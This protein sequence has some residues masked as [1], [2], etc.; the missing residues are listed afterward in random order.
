MIEEK[1][2]VSFIIPVYNS[3]KTIEEIILS[4]IS[5]YCEK[6]RVEIILVNDNSKDASEEICRKVAEK[7][8]RVILIN[9]SKNFGQHN[10]LLTGMRY[11]SGDIVICL[12]DDM[13]NP[14]ED[15]EFLINKLKTGY[16][17]IYG[18]YIEHRESLARRVGSAVNS[19]MATALI[20]KPRNIEITSFFAMKKFIIKEVIKYKGP[21][22]YLPGLIFRATSKIG[23]VTVTHRVR[24]SGKTNYNMEKLISLWMNGF[25][26]YSVKPLRFASLT[27]V[28]TSLCGFIYFTVIIIKK[29]L[30]PMVPLGWTSVMAVILF[31]GG[32]QLLTIGLIGEYIGRMFLSVNEK[33]Q[34]VIKEIIRKKVK[35]QK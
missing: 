33:P 21:Y 6:Y 23:S 32:I 15:I 14:P 35:E 9:L 2:S 10:A 25:T 17:V 34:S 3:E 28:I 22:P 4:I 16:D 8:E 29:L 26:N 19:I 7:E 18:N 11:A 27:G 20:G 24:K 31:L 30:N 13:Q 5:L 12:D 1:M